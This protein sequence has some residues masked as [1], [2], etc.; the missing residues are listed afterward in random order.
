MRP[1]RDIRY[2]INKDNR[3]ISI[4]GPWDKFLKE[5]SGAES[6]RSKSVMNNYL[7]DYI[8]GDDVRQLFYEMF[9]YVRKKG[10][11]VVFRMNC[12]SSTHV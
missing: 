5:N 1:Y 11:K 8:S 7:M 9:E 4:H 6:C 10:Q 3:L 2:T 12:D